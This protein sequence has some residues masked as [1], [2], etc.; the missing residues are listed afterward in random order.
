[1]DASGHGSTGGF[2]FVFFRFLPSG[3]EPGP[4]WISRSETLCTSE[5]AFLG[6]VTKFRSLDKQWKEWKDGKHCNLLTTLIQ[7]NASSS[8]KLNNRIIYND[9]CF[10][11]RSV[12]ARAGFKLQR[13]I[14]YSLEA[15]N[16]SSNVNSSWWKAL[17]EN[18]ISWRSCLVGTNYD[19]TTNWTSSFFRIEDSTFKRLKLRKSFLRHQTVSSF[20]SF[21]C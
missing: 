13:L 1:M 7:K 9:H 14:Y 6:L 21:I 15:E 18:T 5:C 17:R 2:L 10:T 16:L 11:T 8:V 3:L 12:R 4:E 20:I 19:R